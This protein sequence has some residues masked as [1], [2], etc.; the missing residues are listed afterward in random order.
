MP[1][2]ARSNSTNTR[3][4]KRFRGTMAPKFGR[5]AGFIGPIR[6]GVPAAL[7]G[8]RAEK[9]TVDFPGVLVG[10]SCMQ[11]DQLDN[12]P[13]ITCVN[14]TQEGAGFWNRVGRKIMMQSIRWKGFVNFTGNAGANT[15]EYLRMMLIYDRQPN[16]ATPNI[17]DI[18]L[19]IPNAGGA[20]VT[21]AEGGLNMNNSE[22]FMVLRDIQI[23]IPENANALGNATASIIDYKNRGVFDEFIKLKGLETHYTA[24]TGGIGDITT[25]ALF[26]VSY[27]TSPAAGAVFDV[28]WKTR[29]RYK[30]T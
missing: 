20:G 3:S 26:V 17:A 28:S 22:R 4:G 10:N 7:R 1:K 2:R 12:T 30:D 18:L 24:S 27:G 5:P 14:G 15:A 16:K 25:G 9:K 29:L 11:T 19:D 23:A 13:I 8:N 21:S 6:P